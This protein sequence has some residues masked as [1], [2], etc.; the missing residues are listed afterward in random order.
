MAQG[1]RIIPVNIEE[2]MKLHT[3][4]DV[5]YQYVPYDVRWFKTCASPG[6]IRYARYGSDEYKIVQEVR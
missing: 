2:Q 3:I 4:I 6:F 1:E 5:G